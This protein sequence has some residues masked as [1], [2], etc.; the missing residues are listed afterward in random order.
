MRI[1]HVIPTYLPAIRYGGPVRSV[2]GLASAQAERGD[3]V[4]VFTTD[5]DGPRSVPAPIGVPVPLDGHEVS[6]FRASRPRRMARAPAMRAALRAAMDDV[7][8]V[9][10]H[11]VYLW[12]T[13]A[14]ASEARHAGRRYVVSPRGMLDEQLVAR[15]GRWRKRLWIALVERRNLSRAHRIVATSRGEAE[16]LDVL[17]L[18]LA[19]VVV[20]PNG[21]DLRG[22]DFPAG[23][24]SDEVAQAMAGS[25][26]VLHLGRYSWK[27][28]LDLLVEAVAGVTGLRL[29]CA[30]PDDE[31]LLPVLAERARSLGIGDRVRLL[32]SVDG[33]DRTALLRGAAAVALPSLGENFGNAVLEGM[34]CARPVVVT[35]AVGLAPVVDESAC[36]WVVQ[37]TAPAI[38]AALAEIASDPAGARARG[39][40]GRARIEREFT[41]SAVA[42]RMEAAYSAPRAA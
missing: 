40:R 17:G 20:V 41:W 3:H 22:L 31:R 26:F 35:R 39:S 24:V 4:R 14:G 10:L 32:P 42:A 2:H 7:D 16:A 23:V 27:K 30:G 29:V 28:G 33:S 13:Y 12:P 18:S 19:P 15:R 11:S 1:L 8:V 36:G 37:R 9:H 34:A 6:Y 21:V 38:A 25:P 5:I